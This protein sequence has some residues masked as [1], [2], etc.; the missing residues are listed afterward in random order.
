MYTFESRVRFSETDQNGLLKPE[1]VID[2]MQDCS[3]FQSEDGNVGIAYMKELH[4]AWIVNY[5]QID[6]ERMPV[7]GEEIR[8]GTSPYELKSFIGLRNFMIET[9]DG[10]RL[11][12][13]NSMW[14]LFDL[15][16]MR[17]MHVTPEMEAV[18]K[19][20]SKFDME[21]TSRKIALPA[22]GGVSKD[23]IVITESFLDSNHH[24][25]NGQYVRLAAG[26]LATEGDRRP[27]KRLRAEYRAQAKL[28]ETIYPVCYGEDKEGD[29][30]VSLNNA[31]GKPYAVIEMIA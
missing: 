27:L 3:T 30:L 16:A 31:D 14:S 21:Y 20:Q 7:L 13:A 24:V 8:V 9:K 22:E 23:P 19:L 6:I 15:E 11:V 18:Y 17:P 25:N 2:Y 5:W 1:S 28:G 12:N 29:L 26:F 10:K 4:V